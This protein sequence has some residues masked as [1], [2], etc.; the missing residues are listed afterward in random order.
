MLNDSSAHRQFRPRTPWFR[1]TAIRHCCKPHLQRVSDKSNCNYICRCNQIPNCA[2]ILLQTLA[3]YK[4]F[5]FIL[6]YLL[7]LLEL[8]YTSYPQAHSHTEIGG[9]SPSL[10]FAS[11]HTLA[12]RTNEIKVKGPDIIYRNSSGLQYS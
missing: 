1:S 8:H 6:T 3:L 2:L 7:L 11:P 10:F 9:N 12:V 5:T 4:S